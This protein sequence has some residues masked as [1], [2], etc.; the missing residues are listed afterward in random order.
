MK[1]DIQIVM[2]LGNI[3]YFN[4]QSPIFNRFGRLAD[5]FTKEELLRELIT[6][7]FVEQPMALLESAIYYISYSKK[8][9]RIF[10]TSFL[11]LF[12]KNLRKL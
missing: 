3:L 12:G 2:K 4:T 8:W 10:C 9:H 1:F 5:I 6:T 7:L 11:K